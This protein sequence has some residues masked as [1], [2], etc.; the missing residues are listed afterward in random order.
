LISHTPFL[1]FAPVQ[2]SSHR[3]F[4]KQRLAKEITDRA[5]LRYEVLHQ[6]SADHKDCRNTHNRKTEHL[7]Y[8]LNEFRPVNKE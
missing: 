8:T 5:G 1:P 3:C 6:K 2:K 7:L 4:D